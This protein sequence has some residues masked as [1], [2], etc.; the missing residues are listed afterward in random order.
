MSE[1]QHH[2]ILGM[3]WGIRRYQNSDGSLTAAGRE[4]Y[5]SGLSRKDQRWV[6]RK[7]DKIQSN[8]RK[9]VSKDLKKYQ[10]ELLRQPGAVNKDGKLSAST[11]NAYNHRMAELMNQKVSD[12]RSP[13]GK[14]VQFIAKRGEIG[15][16]M[17]LADL[18]Y[19]MSQVKN[20]VWDSGRVAYKKTVLDKT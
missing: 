18:G 16:H 3:K 12:L 1:L 6:E 9:S 7:S 2:G 5:G 17:A 19:D 20:G 10:K 8:V 13:S 14:V 15:V 11:I 4:R